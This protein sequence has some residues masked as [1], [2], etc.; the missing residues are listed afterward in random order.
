MVVFLFLCTSIDV[1]YLS[2][3][4]VWYF[5]GKRR[6]E[7]VLSS[8]KSVVRFNS[9]M[10]EVPIIQKLLNIT[11]IYIGKQINGLVSI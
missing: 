4:K 8:D 6:K 7:F 9:F 1:S 10:T 2:V 11:H 5:L 3:G